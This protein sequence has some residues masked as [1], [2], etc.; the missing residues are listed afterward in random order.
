MS[1]QGVIRLRAVTLIGLVSVPLLA[2]CA[3]TPPK[4]DFIQRTAA[5]RITAGDNVK[6]TVQGAH[7]VKMLPYEQ[8]RFAEEIQAKVAQGMQ[9]NPEV[10]SPRSYEID[11]LVTRYAKGN[12]FARA[13]LAGLGQMHIDGNVSV[14]QMPQHQRLESFGLSKTFAWGGIYGASTSIKDIENAYAEGI[15]RTVTGAGGQKPGS[16]T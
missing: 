16:G 9:S 5:F 11:V 2:G 12:A 10:G 8:E 4:A 1:F 3:G 13:M 6:V 15:E 14:F 7:N